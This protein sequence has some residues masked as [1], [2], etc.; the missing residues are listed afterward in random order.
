[1]T[2]ERQTN[3]ENDAKPKKR[4][5]KRSGKKA[6]IFQFARH[7]E[8]Y[9]KKASWYVGWIDPRGKR[10]AQSCGPEER[11]RTVA[12]RK[13]DK[14]HSELVTGTYESHDKMTWD[15][16]IKLY[17]S[18]VIENAVRSQSADT[19][20]RCLA[21]FTDTMKP[22]RVRMI[23]SEAV[24]EFVMRRRKQTGRGGEPISLA[25]INRDLRYLRQ[26]MRRAK[27]WGIIDDVPEF[28]FQKPLERMPTFVPPD[29]FVAIYAACEIA[30]RPKQVPNVTPADWWR[31]LIVLAY[32][33]GWRIGQILSLKWADVE[34]DAGTALSRADDNKGKRDVLLPLH[35]V[36]VEH[37]KR[38]QT[39]GQT[40]VFAW[41]ANRRAPVGAIRQNPGGGPPSR[42]QAD[43][44]GGQGRTLLRLP[45]PAPRLRDSEC[46]QYGLVPIAG[47]DAA[48]EFGNDK[49][50]RQHGQ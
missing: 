22:N 35:P 40:H 6:W 8:K 41:D 14:L 34:L 38:I 44:E 3:D 45:R 1:M 27:K 33:T 9:G 7:V 43:P 47:P 42:R 2:T 13:A 30:K 12:N 39:F 29:H 5:R 25:T 23:D 18:R 32:M 15:E 16:F 4:I 20:R 26:A 21:I 50:V 10:H 31:A 37:L 24:E 19:A 46:G 28:E 17:E 11:G 48:Q 49:A 36:V